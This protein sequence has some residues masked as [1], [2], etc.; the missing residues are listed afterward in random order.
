MTPKQVLTTNLESTKIGR[1]II[2][3]LAGLL[4]AFFIFNYFSVERKCE[5]KVNSTMELFTETTGMYPSS[6]L[7][8]SEKEQMVKECISESHN[9]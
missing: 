2:L 7:M 4:I 3:L 6:T 1:V 9:Q 5:R 8:R